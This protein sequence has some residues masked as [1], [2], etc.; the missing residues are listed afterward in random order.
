MFDI[1]TQELIIIFIV[2]LLVFG[3]KKLPE[4]A[5]TLGKGVRELKSAM[6]GL[7]DNID[8]VEKDITKDIKRDV[9]ENVFTGDLFDF[10]DRSGEKK[11]KVSSTG[12]DKEE[13]VG[14][15]LQGKADTGNDG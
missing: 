4:L 8:D 12:H 7:K 14:G 6:Q 1:G 10:Q 5:K 15:E 13:D 3:P 9:K 11:D 2:A